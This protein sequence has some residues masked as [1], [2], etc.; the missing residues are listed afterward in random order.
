MENQIAPKN[1]SSCSQGGSKNNASLYSQISKGEKST[2]VR[3][4]EQ[5]FEIPNQIYKVSIFYF[6]LCTDFKIHCILPGIV[7]KVALSKL[8]K[9]IYHQD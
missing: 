6:V 7:S 3:N 4:S 9:I 5:P 8:L 1:T 2:V